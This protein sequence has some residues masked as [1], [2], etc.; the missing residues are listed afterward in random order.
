MSSRLMTALTSLVVG[1]LVEQALAGRRRGLRDDGVQYGA[2]LHLGRLLAQTFL[3][4]ELHVVQ[5]QATLTM[6]FLLQSHV[7]QV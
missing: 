7:A 4:Q 5:F 2:W 6:S 3:E 1:Q